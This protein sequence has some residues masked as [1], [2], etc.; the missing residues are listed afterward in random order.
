MEAGGVRI[1]AYLA[2]LK[3]KEI[4][5]FSET[6]DDALK[7]SVYKVLDCYVRKMGVTSF[8]VAIC[9]PPLGPT[10]ED[11]GGFPVLVR[12]LDRG[13]LMSRTVDMAAMEL[14][15]SSVVFSDPFQVMKALR[16][17]IGEE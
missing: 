3:D 12:I 16:A 7:K 11:W 8:N 15:A 1:L 9:P 6:L 14:Y 17:V 10:K 5:L 4:L 13:D 2:P